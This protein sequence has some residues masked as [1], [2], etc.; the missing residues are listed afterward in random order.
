MAK[1]AEKVEMP[2]WRRNLRNWTHYVYDAQKSRI[3]FQLR[4]GPKEK[5]VPGGEIQLDPDQIKA[6]NEYEKQLYG[7]ENYAKEV[8]EQEILATPEVA[9]VYNALRSIR[10]IGLIGA[11]LLVSEID[12][13]RAR[14]PS[15]LWQ[16]FGLGVLRAGTAKERSSAWEATRKVRSQ[17]IED[18]LGGNQISGEEA[19]ALVTSCLS[20]PD[21]A[22]RREPGL[23]QKDGKKGLPYSNWA[24]SKLVF[25]VGGCLLKAGNERYL[26][27]Y[28]RQ[29]ERRD[30]Q[31]GLCRACNGTGMAKKPK[32]ARPGDLVDEDAGKPVKCWNCVGNCEDKQRFNAW[33]RKCVAI[34]EKA[35]EKGVEPEFP[36]EPRPRFMTQPTPF[37]APWGNSAAHRHQDAVRYKL[38][39]FLADLWTWWRKHEGLP[40]EK[41]YAE[42][43]LGLPV[44]DHHDVGNLGIEDEV[45][46]TLREEQDE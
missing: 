46:S 28:L 17:A 4:A 5:R 12:I 32:R 25:V 21:V 3:A 18:S 8:L 43:H 13:R 23:V 2:A 41:T 11:A 9:D 33:E 37:R 34:A 19:E 29:R 38:K 42:A 45:L 26:G 35:K 15:S 1:K 6:L 30:H 22:M 40:I 10:G 36:P 31:F 24:K 44:S 7:L 16:Y 27:Y 20:E 14:Y 39:M